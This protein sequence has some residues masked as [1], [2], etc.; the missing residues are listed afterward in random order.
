MSA[1]PARLDFRSERRGYT[2]E[3][4]EDLFGAFILR[5]RWYGLSNRRGGGKQQVFM[6]ES[7][8][9]SEVRRITR[10]REKHGYRQP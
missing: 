4:S 7:D 5:R 1:Y 6:N 3:L 10:T 8:A 9:L 2:L